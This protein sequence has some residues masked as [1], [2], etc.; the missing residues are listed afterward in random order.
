M[1]YLLVASFI[2][3]SVILKVIFSLVHVKNDVWMYHD[4]YQ[5]RISR[6]KEYVNWFFNILFFKHDFFS[7]KDA[8]PVYRCFQF[9]V[10][11]LICAL[12]YFIFY[13]HFPLWLFVADY[14]LSIG[15]GIF[16]L[17]FD[18]SFY[19]RPDIFKELT[20]LINS[21][22]QPDTPWLEHI[23]QIGHWS[24]KKEITIA[25]F[26]LS[27]TIGT[28]IYFALSLASFVFWYYICG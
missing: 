5:T 18:W 28:A 21:H 27:A 23:W 14:L 3:V 20:D 26:A 2:A 24:F 11:S 19:Q 1:K 6:G 7:Y 15:A 17:K 8:V 13:S 12:A 22:P 16:F 4:I 10:A 9:L 25:S